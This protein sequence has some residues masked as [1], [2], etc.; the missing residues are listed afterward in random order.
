MSNELLQYVI[1]RIEKMDAKIDSLLEFK[2]RFAGALVI[3]AAL[4]QV[5]VIVVPKLM[6]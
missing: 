5:A 2:W 6:G 3:I 4:I 1:T